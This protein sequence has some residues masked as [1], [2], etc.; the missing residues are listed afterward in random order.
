MSLN[1]LERYSFVL[2]PCHREFL[3]LRRFTDC[4]VDVS[5]GSLCLVI[6]YMGSFI[7]S[8]S[9]DT[10]EIAETPNLAYLQVHDFWHVLFNC[11]TSVVGELALKM[12]EF[13]QTLLPMCFL[14]VAGASWRLK[15][16]QRAALFKHYGPW[17]MRAGRSARDLM[18]IYY[19]KHL[20]EDLDEVRSKWGIIPAPLRPKKK[21][22]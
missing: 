5:D 7:S 1:A 4:T 8:S 9:D 21:V 3:C 12:V 20:H 22:V 13:Q 11:P 15:S 14:S 16:E 2:D 6:S 19:E 10:E 17:A 18:C